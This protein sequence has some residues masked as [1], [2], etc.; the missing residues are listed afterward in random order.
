[1]KT[2][3]FLTNAT[4]AR[5][6]LDGAVAGRL[7]LIPVP[8][9]T[10][11]SRDNF[12]ALFTTWLRLADVII[13]DGVSLKENM[14]WALEALTDAVAARATT[15]V[16]LRLTAAQRQTFNLSRTWHTVLDTEPAEQVAQ[17][18]RTYLDLCEAKNKLSPPAHL[19]ARAPAPV[20][21]AAAGESHRYRDALKALS[22]LLGRNLRERELLREFVALV[23]DLLSAGKLALFTRAPG[24]DGLAI[25]QGNGIAA[26]VSEHLRLTTEGGIAGWLSREVRILHRDQPTGDERIAREFELLG[27]EVAVPMFDNDELTGVLTFSGKITGEPVTKDE[28]ELVYQLLAQ[29]GQ[30]LQNLHLAT[31]VAAQQ[32]LISEVLANVHSGVLVVDEEERILSVNESARE[33]LDL[34]DTPLVGRSL[35]EI[36]GRVGDVVF[37]ALR[38]GGRVTEREVTL[39]R[40]NRPL[41]VHATRFTSA[42]W[43][44]S[45]VV[46]LL[47][48][49][50][51]QKREQTQKRELADREFLMRLA[52]RL[53]HELKNSLAS[54]KVFAQLLPEKYD[55]KDFRDQFSGIVANE[56]NRVDVLVNNLTFFSHPLALVTE[57]VVVTDWIETSLKN[58]TTEFSRKH[59]VHVVGVGEKPPAGSTLPVVQVKKSFGH[60]LARIAGDKL[61][62]MQALEHV[63]RNSLQSLPGG[64]RLSVST[65]DAVDGDLVAGQ[66]LPAGGA[67]KIEVQDSGEGIALD[68]LK[69]VTEPFFTTRNVGVGLGLTIVKKIIERHGGRLVVDSLLGRGTTVGMI[70]PV[71]AQPH[72]EEA[73]L[74]EIVKQA[75]AVDDFGENPA[76]AQS[77]LSKSVRNESGE[78]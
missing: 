32:Q 59:Q 5:R 29:L 73:V 20:T 56:V 12:D 31:R 3:V 13:V 41:R 40:S 72:P 70:V 23:Q 57:E 10:E 44:R 15:P 53:S 11:P 25:A 22:R 42:G 67:I 46:A 60:K 24:R 64:G 37:E 9:P 77:R 55:E 8:A 26:A 7:N 66:A 30:A 47:E 4:D 28:L 21:P 75:G 43:G 68:N 14:R 1:M 76:T 74:R 6:Q 2:A 78:R 36:P 38:L 54:I 61:R 51:Q 33:L 35:D 18:L 65:S 58:V 39:A 34:G 50:T 52:F 63:L 71:Q 17:A 19:P 45:V 27:T 62:L 16:I 49:L 69:R 48:D